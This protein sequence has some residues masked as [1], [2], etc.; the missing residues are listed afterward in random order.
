M[1]QPHE[2]TA[3]QQAAAV[4]RGELDPVDLVEHALSRI[5]A[6]DP[7]LGAFALVTAERARAAARQVRD[8][9]RAGGDD[10]PALLGVPTAIKDLA[11][12]AGV[13]TAFGSRAFRDFVP[14]VD[15]DAARLL[16][17][18]GT[19]S[20]GKTATPELGLP[21][22]TEPVGRPPAVTPWDPGRSAGG[23]SGGAAAAVAGGLVPLAHGTDGG[24]SIRIPAACC[25]LV[26][27][28]TTR[29]LVS[30]GPLGGDPLGMS[31]SGPLARTVADAA[32]MLDALAVPV[33][34]EP[35]PPPARPS[36]GYLETARRAEPGRLRVGRYRTPPVPGVAVDPAC[37]AAYE[38]ASV[39]LGE[40]GHEV[41]DLDPGISPDF[42]PAFET[43]WA[44][45][46][47]AHPVPPAAEDLLEP[48]TR[49]WRAR[50]RAISGPEYLAATQAAMAVT[51]RVVHTHAAAADV[52]L[53]PMLA[54]LPRPVGWFTA[55]GDP[56]VDFERQKA[57]TPFTATYNVTGQ[58][59]LSLPVAWAGPVDGPDDGP[60]LPVSVQL[61]GLRGDDARL[62][63]LGAQLHAALGWD[64]ARRPAV[65]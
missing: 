38:R 21:P 42:L 37:V 57:F 33:P 39:V 28:K 9:L 8:R 19:V 11:L 22:Y 16:R 53:T 62:L 64:A 56:G 29:G 55:G 3:L 60:Q 12:T 30:R 2:L 26:G 1:T 63:A 45:L 31:V 41:A 10:L 40:L 20:L 52:V 59:A 25:G 7:A 47:H 5:A 61:V 35:H 6:L 50:G 17:A 23:S 13:P 18:A 14:D 58:P 46:S 34:G 65:W 48:L 27:L 54:Q 36:A 43:L 51:R 49:W 32:A 4:R 24:G 15:D 44:V